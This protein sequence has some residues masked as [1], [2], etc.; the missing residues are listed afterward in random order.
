M[1]PRIRKTLSEGVPA[2]RN[3]LHYYA[4][5]GKIKWNK[6]FDMLSA[7]I[8]GKLLAI[9]QFPLKSIGFPLMLKKYGYQISSIECIK[10]VG[11]R[12]FEKFRLHFEF[13]FFF[14]T[15]SIC[16][17]PSLIYPVSFLYVSLFR[18]FHVQFLLRIMF[19]VI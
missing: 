19:L 13:E 5:F 15:C 9:F 1:D 2:S 6:F 16:C 18:S 14:V 11:T 4:L 8:I 7:S 10:N 17:I 3:N 12:V